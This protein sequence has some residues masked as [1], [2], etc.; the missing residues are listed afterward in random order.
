M[1]S[2]PSSGPWG[3]CRSLTFALARQYPSASP[4]VLAFR[5]EH[6]TRKWNRFREKSDAPTKRSSGSSDSIRAS[7]ALDPQQLGTGTLDRLRSGNRSAVTTVCDRVCESI[8]CKVWKIA[9]RQPDA[10]P[11]SRFHKGIDCNEIEAEAAGVPR[12]QAL[13]PK[14]RG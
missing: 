7:A 11:A 14:I 9:R 13:S 1:E 10:G 8:D 6:R 2:K 5:L 4:L 12:R 3:S